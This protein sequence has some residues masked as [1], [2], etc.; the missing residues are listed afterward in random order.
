[1]E[2]KKITFDSFIRGTI[3]CVLIIGLLM[4]VER[5]SGVLLPFFLAWLIAYM[6]YPLVK[7]FQYKLRFKSRV[8]SIFCALISITIIGI[9]AFYFLVPPMTSWCCTSLMA[10]PTIPMCP[11][12]FQILFM[13]T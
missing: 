9:T 8:L 12:V 10:Y 11:K 13:K 6:I 3:C 5:L 2:R 4:L 1:M 7:L